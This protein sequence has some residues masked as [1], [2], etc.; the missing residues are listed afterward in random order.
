MWIVTQEWGCCSGHSIL[1]IGCFEDRVTAKTYADGVRAETDAEDV[2][3]ELD[4][5]MYRILR[6]QMGP[7]LSVD[8]R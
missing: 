7:G 8:I 2:D 6:L 3:D 4:R 1:I 5:K